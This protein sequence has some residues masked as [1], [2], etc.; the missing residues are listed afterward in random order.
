[1]FQPALSIR[2]MQLFLFVS[3][4]FQMYIIVHSYQLAQLSTVSNQMACLIYILLAVR[5]IA[6]IFLNFSGG[7]FISSLSML[8]QL[9]R[10]CNF[11]ITESLSSAGRL[12]MLALPGKGSNGCFYNTVQTSVQHRSC[13]VCSYISILGHSCTACEPSFK[14]WLTIYV[15]RHINFLYFESEWK[16]VFFFLVTAKICSF[17]TI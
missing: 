12:R 4:I 16:I 3:H 7:I 8:L 10:R 2:P 17:F 9:S 15:L 5:F 6:C 14:S 1:M 13:C 11:G